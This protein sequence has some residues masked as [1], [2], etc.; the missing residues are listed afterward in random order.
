MKFMCELV[1]IEVCEAGMGTT[2]SATN[3][4]GHTDEMT[5]LATAQFSFNH[6]IGY[7]ATS[8]P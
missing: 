4:I 6:T 3:Y 1:F 7:N 2:T 8:A 5:I